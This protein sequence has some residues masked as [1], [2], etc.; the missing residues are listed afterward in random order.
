MKNEL[1]FENV[2]G[3]GDL[4]LEYVFLEFEAEPILFTCV[5]RRGQL[6]ICLCSE[7][8]AEQRWLVSGCTLTM[9]RKLLMQQCDIRSAFCQNTELTVIR[10]NIMGEE[11]S[12][13][14]G[15]ASVDPLDLPESG[16]SLRGDL[17]A[18]VRYLEEKEHVGKNNK[19]MSGAEDVE[20]CYNVEFDYEFMI[21]VKAPF[22]YETK[23]RCFER[24]A[25]YCSK[26][27]DWY[28][29]EYSIA[30]KNVYIEIANYVKIDCNDFEDYLQAA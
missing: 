19:S 15:K 30:K 18:A 28:S 3:I 29:D 24:L 2:A 5:T 6:Y 20:R 16:V 26:I 7:I 27:Y 9:L 25:A 4:Y 1:Y 12:S 14:I 23:R 11:E 17:T 10:R 21:N 8:R 22:D 13:V